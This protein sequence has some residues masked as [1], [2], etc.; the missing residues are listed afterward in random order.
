MEVGNFPVFY[1][2]ILRINS[3]LPPSHSRRDG[4]WS[5]LGDKLH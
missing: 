2:F 5:L 3:Y 4:D 1:F